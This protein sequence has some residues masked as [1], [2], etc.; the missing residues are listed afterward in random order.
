M[1]GMGHPINSIL[2]IELT[3]FFLWLARLVENGKF[4]VRMDYRKKVVLRSNFKNNLLIVH[5]FCLGK[6]INFFH[7]ADGVVDN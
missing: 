1:N 5:S 2:C 4:L 7:F 6:K 3:S